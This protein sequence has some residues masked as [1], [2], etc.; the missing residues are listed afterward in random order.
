M[1]FYETEFPFAK[2]SPPSFSPHVVAPNF[3][4][5]SL[6]SELL[7]P[8]LDTIQSEIIKPLRNVELTSIRILEYLRLS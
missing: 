3:I 6:P 1:H 4:D 8:A 5:H 2:H 7:T